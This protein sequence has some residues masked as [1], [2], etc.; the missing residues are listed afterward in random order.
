MIA[1]FGNKSMYY[2]AL[3]GNPVEHSV[4][5]VMYEYFANT[6]GIEYR[7]LKIKAEQER[8]EQVLSS[9]W[10]LGFCG[11]NVTLPFKQDVIQYVDKLDADGAA[12]GAVNT[13]SLRDG[14]TVGTNTDWIGIKE[15]FAARNIHTGSNAVVFGSGGAARAAIYALKNMGCKK[16][17]VLYKEPIDKKTRLL[18]DQADALGITL[19]TYE[20]VEQYVEEADLVC[21]MSSAGMKGKDPA[22]FDP[23]RLDHVNCAPKAFLDAVFNPVETPLLTYFNERGSVTVDGLWMMMYQGVAAFEK[24]TGQAVTLQTH[25]LDELHQQLQQEIAK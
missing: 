7:H 1:Y 8:L 2:T 5:P 14:T 15:A 20:H 9:L 19:A 21:N 6:C 10:E 17:T 12:C 4:S 13:I 18:I 23:R 16:I 11:I 22:P 25:E 24:W 3:I